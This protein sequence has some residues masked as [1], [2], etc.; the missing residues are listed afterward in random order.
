LT[1]TV[2]RKSFL[3]RVGGRKKGQL[4]SF[5]GTR[6]D[7]SQRTDEIHSWQTGQVEDV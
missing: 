7:S 4:N 5:T 1:D 2:V 6:T 3:P